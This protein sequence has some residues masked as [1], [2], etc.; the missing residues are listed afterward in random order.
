ML[1]LLVFYSFW[2]ETVISF[3]DA[4]HQATKEEADRC[5]DMIN[6]YLIEAGFAELYAGNPYDWIF[7]WANHN[8]E[9]LTAFRAYILELIAIKSDQKTAS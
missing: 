8:E 2:A 3:Q 7:L 1:I 9:P 5:L 4:A 6:R